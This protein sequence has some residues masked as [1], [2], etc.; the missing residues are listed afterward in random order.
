MVDSQIIDD[1]ANAIKNTNKSDI[2]VIEDISEIT[3]NGLYILKESE[4]PLPQLKLVFEDG[5]NYRSYAHIVGYE[6]SYDDAI[7]IADGETLTID[8]GDGNIVTYTNE[9]TLPTNYTFQT[10]G[11]HTVIFDFSN[12]NIPTFGKG[13]SSYTF[14][15]STGIIE[16][17]YP[18]G[19]TEIYKMGTYDYVT[20]IDIPIT[21]T[22][23][24]ELYTNDGIVDVYWTDANDIPSIS[25]IDSG[26]KV[27]IPN[28]TTAIYEANSDWNNDGAT[29]FI[30]RGA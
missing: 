1:F 10:S 30:E 16:V 11:R 28:G 2:T 29:V 18:Y 8:W 14:E 25:Y 27:R 17:Y 6:S 4:P 5:S 26:Q 24:P 15:E 19:I 23:I 21:A 22:N 12:C 9:D 20:L 7:Y 13:S 3:S